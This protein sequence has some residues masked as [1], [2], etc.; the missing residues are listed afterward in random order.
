MNHTTANE[1][2]GSAFVPGFT[3]TTISLSSSYEKEVES[4]HFDEQLQKIEV[5][6]R[7]KSSMVYC[8]FP[9]KPVPDR[10]W[11][12]IYGISNGRIALLKVIPGKHTPERLESESITFDEDVA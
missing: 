4:F 10:V 2:D 6:F 11:K 1:F 3:S 8:T 9:T 7:Q 12:E 5:V